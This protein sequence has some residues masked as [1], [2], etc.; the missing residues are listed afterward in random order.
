MIEEEQLQAI[1]RTISD[2]LQERMRISGLDV[3]ALVEKSGVSQ[4]MIY[5]IINCATNATISILAKLAWAL[6]IPV[7]VMVS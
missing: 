6:D 5:L 1:L 7:S 2:R 4:A 3:P